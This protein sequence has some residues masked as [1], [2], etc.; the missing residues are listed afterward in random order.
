MV[1]GEMVE[2]LGLVWKKHVQAYKLFWI[3]KGYEVIVTNHCKVLFLI[4]EYI[5]ELYYDVVPMDAFHRLAT[6]P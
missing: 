1:A 4:G 2:K 6:R 5:Y 3:Q